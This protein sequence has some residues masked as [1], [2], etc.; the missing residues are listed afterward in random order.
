MD[1]RTRSTLTGERFPLVSGSLSAEP[2]PYL[3]HLR[4]EN[5][6][7]RQQGA[8][9]CE[10][11]ES[12]RRENQLLR[13]DREEAERYARSLEGELKTLASRPV[14]SLRKRLSG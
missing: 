10:Y 14:S 13:Q 5:A 8:E 12:L 1:G 11:A 7:L 9:A 4:E 3:R 6:A 2:Y